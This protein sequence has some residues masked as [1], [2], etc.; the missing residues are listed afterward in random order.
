MKHLLKLANSRMA[1]GTRREYFPI[2]VAYKLRFQLLIGKAKVDL[3]N[4]KCL[5]F[6]GQSK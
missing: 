5:I 3:Q 2:G 6:F 4:S 1:R